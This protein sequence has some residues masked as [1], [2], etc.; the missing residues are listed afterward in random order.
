[1]SGISIRIPT[2]SSSTVVAE[3]LRLVMTCGPSIAGA[4]ACSLVA[5]SDVH[6]RPH[7]KPQ[8]RG[9]GGRQM[10]AAL[11]FLDQE[12]RL[13]IGRIREIAVGLVQRSA[14]PAS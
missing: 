4:A 13:V 2:T 1:L 9:V 7:L 11:F 6:R 8:G 12:D 3:G 5:G 10:A 14:R